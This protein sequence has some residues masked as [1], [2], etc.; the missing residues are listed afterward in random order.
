M[1]HG[2]EE[3]T[4]DGVGYIFWKGVEI[5]HFNNPLDQSMADQTKEMTRRCWILESRGIKPDTM[6]AVW[7]WDEK[8][9]GDKW[10]MA[11]QECEASD[12]A[13]AA[14]KR[15]CMAYG[16]NGICDPAYVANVIET[17]FKA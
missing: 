2:I 16:I 9:N 8:G 17:E 12:K 5:E 1:L 11:F 4:F 3:I 13:Q 14:S 6:T 7:K 10:E 15:I